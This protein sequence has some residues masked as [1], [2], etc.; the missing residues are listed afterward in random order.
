MGRY[1]HTSILRSAPSL[2]PGLG[3]A[4]RTARIDNSPRDSV[5]DTG[6]TAFRV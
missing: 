2:L 5:P 3:P 4:A 1:L 6:R